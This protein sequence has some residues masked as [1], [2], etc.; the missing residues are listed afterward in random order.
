MADA[1]AKEEVDVEVVPESAW[2][3]DQPM[4]LVTKRVLVRRAVRVCWN[5]PLGGHTEGQQIDKRLRRSGHDAVAA[6][7]QHN[8]AFC[9]QEIPG[10][11]PCYP[12]GREP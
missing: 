12:V 6:R 11:D 1:D 2:D 7:A 4:R 3:P 10:C 8:E 9:P 5:K